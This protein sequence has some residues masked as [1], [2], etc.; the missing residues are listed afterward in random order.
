MERFVKSQPIFFIVE[1]NFL[2][3]I[4]ILPTVKDLRQTMQTLYMQ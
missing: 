1:E 2:Q 4:P 3:A